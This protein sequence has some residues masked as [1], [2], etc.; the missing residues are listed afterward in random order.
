MRQEDNSYSKDARSFDMFEGLGRWTQGLQT[1][2]DK[3]KKTFK[4]LH[5]NADNDVQEIDDD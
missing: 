3:L 5:L 2:E 4:K 1:L